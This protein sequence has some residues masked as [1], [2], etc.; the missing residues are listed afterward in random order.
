MKRILGS[1]PCS[2]PVVLSCA[3]CFA[4]TSFRSALCSPL[5]R[6]QYP[7][8]CLSGSL[9]A[10]HQPAASH[11]ATVLILSS[12]TGTSFV[13]L[14]IPPRRARPTAV[15]SIPAPLPRRRAV[16]ASPAFLGSLTPIWR[17]RLASPP[18]SM[19]PSFV[20]RAIATFAS[21]ITDSDA[22]HGE[23]EP[24]LAPPAVIPL[25]VWRVRTASA[26]SVTALPRIWR[27]VTASAPILMQRPRIRRAV[28]AFAPLVTLRPRIW[29]ARAASV[30][31][32]AMLSLRR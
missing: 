1:L 15:P 19:V 13:T 11:S 4:V 29:R 20:R 17:A 24:P 21:P 16:S 9:Q 2:L 5:S 32:I 12:F 27:A 7:L 26:F 28:A 25:R 23:R 6:P 30:S 10:V 3:P 22:D 18:P 8:P 14:P 31:P